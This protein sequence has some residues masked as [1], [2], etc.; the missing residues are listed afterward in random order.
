MAAQ[1]A[2]PLRR[3]S[4]AAATTMPP[5]A[6][7]EAREPDPSTAQ[8]CAAVDALLAAVRAGS[9]AWAHPALCCRVG[10]LGRGL[11][12]DRDVP[13]GT[14][15]AAIPRSLCVY[16]AVPRASGGDHVAEGVAAHH[17]LAALLLSVPAPAAAEDTAARVR[18]AY[19]DALPARDEA[20]AFPLCWPEGALQRL[21]D[22]GDAESAA[23][24]RSARAAAQVARAAAAPHA[25]HD[26]WLWAQAMAQSRMY[27]GWPTAEEMRDNLANHAPFAGLGAP[28]K[29]NSLYQCFTLPDLF[30]LLL[31]K[32]ERESLAGAERAVVA[33]ARK[34]EPAAMLVS[35]RRLGAGQEVLVSYCEGD[36]IPGGGLLAA[37]DEL[38]LYGIS[39]AR[40]PRGAAFVGALSA[41]DHRA[42]TG[43][44]EAALE[45]AACRTPGPMAGSTATAV[46]E[47]FARVLHLALELWSRD[48]AETAA[49][50]ERALAAASAREQAASRAA[51]L[52][53]RRWVLAGG[54]AVMTLIRGRMGHRGLAQLRAGVRAGV[55]AGLAPIAD[56][57]GAA[58]AAALVQLIEDALLTP[59]PSPLPLPRDDPFFRNTTG[60]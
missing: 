36:P 34:Q 8:Q 32:Y 21:H 53:A 30:R 17:A 39:D 51:A 45:E 40:A 16:A 44:F 59:L 27:P 26:D 55:A 3:R 24:V 46:D 20:R 19:I 50:V 41:D 57:E 1:P 12:V 4:R 35:I 33:A 18:A 48:V 60:A 9:G 28:Q 5:R 10:P 43:A 54:S 37:R 22:L 25:S 11:F 56:A 47:A 14:I 2:P 15:L 38:L 31:G 52:H 29:R 49:H 42:A 7:S 58:R 6:S 13:A 23:N